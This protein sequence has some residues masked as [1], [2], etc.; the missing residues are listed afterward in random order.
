MASKIAEANA[1]IHSLAMAIA[2]SW[3][4]LNCVLLLSSVCS[5]SQVGDYTV[6]KVLSRT[7]G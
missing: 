2:V 7:S 6:S 3:A 5:L 4:S 1:G